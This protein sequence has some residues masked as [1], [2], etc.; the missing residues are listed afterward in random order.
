M[1]SCTAVLPASAYICNKLVHLHGFTVGRIRAYGIPGY[2]NYVRCMK[3]IM[4]SKFENG[5]TISVKT[6]RRKLSQRSMKALT[7]PVPLHG[8]QPAKLKTELEMGFRPRT[9]NQ[10]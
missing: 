6:S 4:G 7:M 10:K 8:H 2:Q 1:A 3:S 9:G 5:Q